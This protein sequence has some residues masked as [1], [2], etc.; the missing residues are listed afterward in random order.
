MVSWGRSFKAALVLLAFMIL[1]GIL[2]MGVVFSGLFTG[3]FGQM[4]NITPEPPYF[5][6][7]WA[8]IGI[9][10]ILAII[11]SLIIFLGTWASIFKIFTELIVEEVGK[12]LPATP[13][14]QAAAPGASAPTCPKCGTPLTYVQQYQRWYCSTC[15]EYQ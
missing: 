6:I 15:R 9:G 12:I 7:N 1:W 10:V 14:T 5:T 11:G 8:A 2:G 4:F 13:A 3:I